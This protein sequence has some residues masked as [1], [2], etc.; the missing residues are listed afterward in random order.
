MSK[1]T[2]SPLLC[3][4]LFLNMQLDTGQTN[5]VLDHPIK[6]ETAHKSAADT[7]LVASG[8]VN[9]AC[10]AVESILHCNNSWVF[11]LEPEVVE[12][13]W[14]VS[15]L[16]IGYSLHLALLFLLLW[17]FI[18]LFLPLSSHYLYFLSTISLLTPLHWLWLHH[19]LTSNYPITILLAPT[20]SLDFLTW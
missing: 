3:L 6:V 20:L 15:L 7:S 9:K 10:K 19:N 1:P 17:L 11:F 14:G 5:S 13:S 12:R 4:C 16:E 18:L 2:S 8:S